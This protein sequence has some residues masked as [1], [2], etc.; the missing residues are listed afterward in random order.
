MADVQHTDGA[1]WERFPGSDALRAWARELRGAH[2]A[3]AGAAEAWELVG[4][5][6]M[7][8]G[9]AAACQA[10]LRQVA[11][12]AGMG[13]VSVS[14]A[15][16]PDLVPQT[17]SCADG[18][19]NVTGEWPM[20]A[21]RKLAPVIV[22]LERGPWMREKPEGA[23]EPT[24]AAM[25]DFRSFLAR[26]IGEFDC[27]EPVIVVTSADEI[28]DMAE[29]LRE[30]GLFDRF[31]RLAPVTL[32]ADG[33]EFIERVGAA[34][35][36]ASI[37]E[38]PAKV[39]KLVRST[40]EDERRLKLAAL[41][42]RRF[43]A[44]SGR[45]LEFLDLVHLSHCGFA[46]ADALPA[47]ADHFRRQ[48]AYHEAGHAVVAVIGSGGENIPE[49]ASVAPTA[50]YN[51]VMVQSYAYGLESGDFETYADFRERVRISLAG[52]AAEELVFGAERVSNG[53]TEDLRSAT[54]RAGTAFA[55]WGFAPAMERE[56]QTASNLAVVDSDAPSASETAHVERLVREFLAAEYAA[57]TAMLTEHRAL[58]DAIAERLLREPIVDQEA[59]MEL[60][61]QQVPGWEPVD[62]QRAPVA[63]GRSANPIQARVR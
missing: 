62:C 16:V 10:V 25:K 41:R 2:E 24:I 34:L 30:A 58:L 19:V 15:D 63:L 55:L 36:G 1:G 44:R 52:R 4:H 14:A 11:A 22:H 33:A 59:I 32:T 23:D 31:L 40:Y 53:C 5:A 49:Y 42:T 12:E 9:R 39:G 56:G 46:E 13:Y 50:Q 6:A 26:W 61:R 45:P 7:V 27:A 57:V 60:V 17:E 37:T 29:S 43:I 48:T 8:I 3:G 47:P 21:W 38:S 18:S 28:P 35:C 54:D 51:G 20:E